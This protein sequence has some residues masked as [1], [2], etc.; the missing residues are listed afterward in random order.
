MAEMRVAPFLHALSDE[1][2]AELDTLGPR[3]TF[4]TGSTILA[5]GELANRVGIAIDGLMKLTAT[6]SDGHRTVLALRG[7]GELL[8]EMS[9]LDGGPRT[10]SV[11]ALVPCCVQ[12]VQADE[13]IRFMNAHPSASLAVIR[14]LVARLRESDSH[15]IQYGADGVPRRLARQLLQLADT[16]GTVGADYSIDIS[17]PFTQDDLASAVSAS[18]DAVARALKD[19]RA[20]GLVATGRRRVTLLDPAALSRQNSL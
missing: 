18:R 17:L 8:G 7:A 15:R 3:R 12:L 14:T 5:E 16:H 11:E 2:R 10:A 20:Q 19:W 6:Q 1:A 9:A 13:F 4:V